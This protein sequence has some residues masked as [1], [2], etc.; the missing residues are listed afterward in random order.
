MFGLQVTG[1]MVG[2]CDLNEKFRSL[3]RIVLRG[4]RY[5]ETEGC[6]IEDIVANEFMPSFEKTVKRTFQYNNVAANYGFRV[7]G[8]RE[9]AH[10]PRV[11]SLGLVLS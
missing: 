10:D 2:A 3:L 1:A 8:L 4:E 11:R 5:L 7:R 9:S 6:T